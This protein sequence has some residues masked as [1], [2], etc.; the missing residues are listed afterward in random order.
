MR[1]ARFGYRR[2]PFGAPVLELR[3]METYALLALEHRFPALEKGRTYLQFLHTDDKAFCLFLINP[4]MHRARRES[5]FPDRTIYQEG[6]QAFVDFEYPMSRVG[7]L[8]EMLDGL[9]RMPVPRRR[10]VRAFEL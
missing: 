4:R 10:R 3:A 7:V 6:T 2:I 8:G 5:V 1:I 9:T